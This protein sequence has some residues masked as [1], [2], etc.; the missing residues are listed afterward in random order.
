MVRERALE[1][2]GMKTFEDLENTGDRS[3]TEMYVPLV[4]FTVVVFQVLEQCL[5]HGKHS[6]MLCEM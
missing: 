2:Q 4:A 3:V 6:V 1:E 5:A